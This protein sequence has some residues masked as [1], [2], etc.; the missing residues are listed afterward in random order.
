MPDSIALWLLIGLPML[1][2]SV[3]LVSGWLVGLGKQRMRR[4]VKHLAYAR[5]GSSFATFSDDFP[6]GCAPEILRAVYDTFQRATAW[7]Q[8]IDGFVVR[9]DDD[10]AVIYDAHLVSDYNDFEDLD[11]RAVVSE[12]AAAC[13]RR[14]FEPHE[15]RVRVKLKTVRDVVS[16]LER[17]PRLSDPGEHQE[18]AG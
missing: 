13:N 3:L 9:A 11:L 16:L 1:F 4:N 17:C 15:V 7:H 6:A 8:G 14:L 5:R 10:L 18:A 2:V 12:A